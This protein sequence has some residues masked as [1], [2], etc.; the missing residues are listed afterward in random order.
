M[1]LTR[2]KAAG[3]GSPGGAGLARAPHRVR[4]IGGRY[5]RT[6]IQVIDAPGLRP[7]PDRVRETVFNWLAHLA[8][9]LAALRGLDLFAG[10]GALGF[11]L[12]SRGARRVVL[13]ER[14][15]RLVE[16]LRRLRE[17]LGAEE[18]EIIAADWLE[19]VRSLPPGGFDLVFVD[20]PFDA[21]LMP[22]VLPRTRA[23]LAPQGMIYAEA[24]API[25]PAQARACGLEVVR[26]A[27]NGMV[28]FHLLRALAS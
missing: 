5:R 7:T 11:E 26:S 24:G 25:D 10:S 9:D 19:A 14:N 1:A 28:H 3:G 18:V 16:Q 6:P 20:P 27:R 23:L 17:R 15:P 21:G 8:G 2:H 4:I 22:A 12:A 13:V